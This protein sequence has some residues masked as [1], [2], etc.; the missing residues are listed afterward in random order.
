MIKDSRITLR[1]NSGIKK[2]ID[3]LAQLMEISSG[4]LIRN[5]IDDSLNKQIQPQ[6]HFYQLSNGIKLPNMKAVCEELDISSH[7]V[8]KL[9]KRDVIKK[10]IIENSQAN[11]YGKELPTDNS[12]RVERHRI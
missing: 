12:R 10:I 8:R 4:Q 2:Q 11:E 5:W 9:I 6:Q 1:I 3:Q 7:K